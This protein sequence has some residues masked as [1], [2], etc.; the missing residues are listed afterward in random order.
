MSEIP[1]YAELHC[2][3]NFS[4]QRGASHAEELIQ[5]AAELGY[6]ALAITDECSM[7]GIV[8][9]L[10]AAEKHRLKLIVGTEITLVCG[11]RLVLLAPDQAS[12]S[13][14]CRLITRGRRNAEKGAYRLARC[15]LND[16]LANSLVLWLPGT[17]A[18]AK[19]GR[20]L[21]RVFPERTWIA[22]E[23]LLEGD[24]RRRLAALIRMGQDLDLPLTACGDVHMHRRGR[25]ALQDVLTAIRL[26]R[27]VSACREA[28]FSNGER[29]L[30]S[31]NRLAGIY[32]AELL[33]ASTTIADRCEFSLRD[34]HYEYPEE[35][36]PAGLTPSAHLRNLTEEG[37]R[38]R[39]PEGISPAVRRQIDHELTLI[40]EMGYEAFFLTVY[41]IVAFARSRH[42]LCQ[43]R[44]SAANSAVCFCLGI[45]EVDPMRMNMLFER[46]I[47]KERNEPPDIDVDFEHDRREEVL[48]YI[49]A[50]YGRHR[51]A[52]AATVITYR[53]RSAIRDVG[54]ALGLDLE[55]V[56]RLAK[57]LTYWD[58]PAVLRERL[59]ERGFDADN[60]V[61]RKLL[62]L[63]HT[64]RGFPRHLSQHVGGFV[65]AQQPLHHLV[66]VENAA[67]DDRTIIQW[68]K[69]DLETLGLLKVDC[70]ALGML[71][72]I[73]RGF[74]L[75]EACRGRRY[76]LATVPAEDP[77]VYAMVQRADTI[78]V[79]QIESRAQ[80][81]MLPRLKPACYYDLVIEVAIVRPG[82]IQGKMV[83]PYL[84]RRQGKE[85]VEYPSPDLKAVFERTLGVPIFQEQVMQLAIVAAGFTPGEAD[86]LR[87]SMAAWKR[88]GGLDHF[89]R[90]IVQGMRERGYD[91]AFARQVFEQIKGFGSYGFPE[92]HAAS[93]ALLVYVSAWMKCHEP[94]AFCCA[95]LN[96]QPMGFYSPSQLVQDARAHD[97]EVRPADVCFSHWDCTLEPGEGGEPALRLGLRQIKG[98]RQVAADRIAAERSRSPF[99][100]IEDLVDRC[101]LNRHQRGALARADALRSLAGHRHQAQWAIAGIQSLPPILQGA[102]VPDAET[103]LPCPGEAEEILADYAST[104]LT[105]NRHP[106]SLLRDSLARR[107]AMT[108]A[109]AR[110]MTSGSRI[111]CAGLVT[112]RQRP[113]TASGVTFL[114]LEDETGMLNVI[115]WR[116]LAEA[117]RREMLESDLLG[118]DGIMECQQGVYHLIA[119]RLHNYNDLIGALQIRARNFC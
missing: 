72:A 32:P 104:G 118:V 30:R 68:D 27:P 36:T 107:R 4:F 96:S 2:L 35:L 57:A 61:I 42:I 111:R 56:D 90:R 116:D 80:M 82:P 84:R 113:G 100:D 22:V 43:G 79:F 9:A 71:S 13:A 112:L 5:R 81:S 89:E 7:A 102:R 73:R 86:R 69:D 76:S 91:E 65:I 47:S 99:R 16:G 1:S 34:L 117:Q 51:A 48:Q 33:A 75:I 52:L 87:R 62:I 25:R 50:K 88:R 114:T 10:E 26:N 115:I 15:D 106:L 17:P 8:R 49:Y 63:V 44:G 46:F 59:A 105:L 98:M 70:L 101:N 119:Q 6:H 23:L 45:T 11:L 110:D 66:P 109:D 40:E 78:G 92:S 3:S 39:W 85:P 37:I 64:L 29:H 67:M 55:Q 54:K 18:D 12:Y 28:L 19:Q 58:N 74:E 53:A 14:L 93:F 21:K 83:H 103:E 108:T 95:L 41:D 24:D 60:P 94:A 20:W 31:R 77:A 97:V 38:R